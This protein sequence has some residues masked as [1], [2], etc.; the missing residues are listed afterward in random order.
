MTTAELMA[1][2]KAERR[3][4]PPRMPSA[5]ALMEKAKR[6][7]RRKQKNAPKLLLAALD[8]RIRELHPDVDPWTAA[9]RIAKARN[10]VAFESGYWGVMTLEQDARKNGYYDAEDWEITHEIAEI[11]LD[12]LNEQY[13]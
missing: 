4:N 5:E 8:Y 9:Q 3:E 1:R 7:H 12:M 13:G 2:I 6:A 11:V 10:S